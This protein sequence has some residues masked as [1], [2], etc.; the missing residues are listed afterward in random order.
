MNLIKR[1]K[2]QSESI[3]EI[4]GTIPSWIVRWGDVIASVVPNAEAKIEGRMKVSSVG[5]G[6]VENGQTVNVRLKGFPHIEFG[7]LKGEITRIFQV[8]EKLPDGSVA[9]NVEVSFPT[10]LVS[11][12]RKT[13]P[14]IQDMDGE[15]EI[16]TR[17][18]R[19]IEYFVEP[20]LSL[21]R[22][23]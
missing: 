18:K 2:C 10:G 22:N 14:F 23:R 15:A 16:I 21:F 19:L 3:Q 6:R 4:M 13:L 5:F 11:T 9:Y 1:E 17:D 8:P 20:M 12:Y 7:I